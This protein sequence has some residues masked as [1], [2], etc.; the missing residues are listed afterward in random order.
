[1]AEWRGG[2]G[3]GRG[4]ELGSKASFSGTLVFCPSSTC[5]SLFC[6]NCVG[7]EENGNKM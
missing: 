6:C 7:R 3:Q 5:K 1:M 4:W 2:C